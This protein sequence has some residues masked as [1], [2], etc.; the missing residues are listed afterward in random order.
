M[1]GDDGWVWGNLLFEGLI[2]IIIDGVNGSAYKL[3]SEMY[4]D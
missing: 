3:P 1:A 4:V 2:G